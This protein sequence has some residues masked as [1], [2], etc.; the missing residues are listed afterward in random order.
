VSCYRRAGE[1]GNA[2][3]GGGT[4]MPMP[5]ASPQDFVAD[6]EAH[7][8]LPAGG[9]D[10]FSGYAVMG[11]YFSSGDVLA[12]RRFSISSIGPAYAS[13]WHRDQTG[14]WT[15]Y[16]DVTADLGCAR[17][18]VGGISAALSAPI[19]IVWTSAHSFT[20][21]VDG[22]STIEWHVELAATTITGSLRALAG[23]LPAAR[24][25]LRPALALVARI[26]RAALRTGRLRFSGRTPT[27][28]R[29]LARPRGLWE[30]RSSRAVI[31]QRHTGQPERP[32]M[33]VSLGDVWLPR[34]PLFVVASLEMELPDALPAMA[35]TV[36]SAADDGRSP[37]PA[38]GRSDETPP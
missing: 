30:V 25:R 33:Q 27:G 11:V 5:H 26:V 18:F 22:G 1:V 6:L 24:W 23:W 16:Q 29:F 13:V 15:F 35:G 19:Q 38:F 31:G 32:R 28:H 9:H 17:Y 14:H 34:R 21:L 3:P 12:L 7:P 4:D 8:V 37:Q 36:V 20:V 10:R 2:P